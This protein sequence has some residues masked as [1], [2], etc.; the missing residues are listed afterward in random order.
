MAVER[1]GVGEVE[2]VDE[3]RVRRR[4]AQERAEG[5]VDVQP[6]TVLAADLG[7]LAERIARAGVRRGRVRDHDRG[8]NAVRAVA[9]DRRDERRG[10]SGGSAS[11]TGTCRTQSAPRPSVRSAFTFVKC[12]SVLP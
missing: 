3:V 1:D 10:R 2:A 7:D 12:S 5:A 11:S 6:E 8:T 9:L 4:R